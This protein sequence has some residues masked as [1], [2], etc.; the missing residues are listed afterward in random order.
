MEQLWADPIAGVLSVVLLGVFTAGIG[1]LVIYVVLRVDRRRPTRRRMPVWAAALATLLLAIG[2]VL[3]ATGATDGSDPAGLRGRLL[4]STLVM[5]GAVVLH[6]GTVIICVEAGPEAFT[7]RGFFGG[8][9][10]VRYADI[11]DVR[12]YES[13]GVR[14]LTV[15]GRDGRKVHAHRTMFD[16][17]PYDAWRG[18]QGPGAGR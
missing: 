10:T 1:L 15:E 7:R 11:T 12:D 18:R 9:R 3:A 13:R 8:T 14:T 4:A 16:W 17:G 2:A 6:W 5:L